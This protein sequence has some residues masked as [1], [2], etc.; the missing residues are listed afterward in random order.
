MKHFIQVLNTL[1][2]VELIDFQASSTISM[3]D[4]DV[5]RIRLN[6]SRNHCCRALPRNNKNIEKIVNPL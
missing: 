6:Q 5:F 3:D 1:L 4:D 2:T